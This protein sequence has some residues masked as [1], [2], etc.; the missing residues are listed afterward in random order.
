M[1]LFIHSQAIVKNIDSHCDE[2]KWLQATLEDLAE[3]SSDREVQQERARLGGVLERYQD[4]MPTIEVTETKS[5]LVVRCYEYKEEMEQKVAWLNEAEEKVREDIPLDD[6]Q[7]VSVLV[8]EQ[9]VFM[10]MFCDS[11][12]ITY[13]G[14]TY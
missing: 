9:E 12:L 13:N 11:S 8:E 3:T 1:M 5:S 2:A 14:V 7:S 6:V 4:L 10:Y